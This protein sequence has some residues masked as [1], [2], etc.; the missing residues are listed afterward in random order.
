M[1]QQRSRS[2]SSASASAAPASAPQESGGGAAE[3]GAAEA[4][5]QQKQLHDLPAVAKP[6]EM[7]RECASLQ[8]RPESSAKVVSALA[9]I[10]AAQHVTQVPATDA[11]D[12]P[13]IIDQQKISKISM[14]CDILN[15]YRD[16]D[17]RHG[18]MLIYVCAYMY[19][20]MYTHTHTHKHTHTH[21][22]TYG[23][24]CRH[25]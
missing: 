3:A 21:T 2:A 12:H 23:H 5:A 25:T 10:T 24:T 15:S 6:R 1:Q 7:D 16:V 4:E 18:C 19:V 8:H 20:Y 22:H 13:G 17:Q 14:L 9:E 11:T